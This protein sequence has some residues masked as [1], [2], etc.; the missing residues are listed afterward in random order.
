MFIL[1]LVYKA[2]P[3]DHPRYFLLP[4]C[5]EALPV[6]ITNNQ[7]NIGLYPRACTTIISRERAPGSGS[8]GR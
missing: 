1:V 6:T 7:S 8:A 2:F 5:E 3:T 4:A